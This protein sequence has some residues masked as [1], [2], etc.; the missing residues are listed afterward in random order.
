MY[1]RPGSHLVLL[2]LRVFDIN[3]MVLIS[4]M[5]TPSPL[6]QCLHHIHRRG[7]KGILRVLYLFA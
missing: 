6:A 4:N 1:S 3:G 7:N 2:E 5:C